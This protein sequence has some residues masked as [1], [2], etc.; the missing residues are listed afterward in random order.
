MRIRR[1]APRIFAL[2]AALAAAA[3][4]ASAVVPAR[5]AGVNRIFATVRGVT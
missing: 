5:D 4:S 1:S 2:A 3:C